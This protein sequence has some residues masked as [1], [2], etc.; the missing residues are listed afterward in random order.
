L[1]RV[2]ELDEGNITAWLWLSTVMETLEEKQ[3]CLENVLTLDPENKAART[4][5]IR[6]D[7]L[8]RAPPAKPHPPAPAVSAPR[9]KKAVPP[10][11]P[12]PE[13]TTPAKPAKIGGVLCP[14]CR[15]TI[16]VLVTTCPH[17]RLP[18]VVNCPACGAEVDVERPICA[19]CGQAMGYYRRKLPYFEALAAA[20]QEQQRYAEAL[21]AWQ[22]VEAIEPA[23]P[24]LLLHLGKAQVGLGR[25]DR[26][27]LSFQSALKANPNSVQTHYALGELLRQRGEVDQA[28]AHYLKITRLDPKHG[29]A[30]LRLGQLYEQ[31]RRRQEAVQAYRRAGELLGSNSVES[32]QAR[33]QLELLQPSL[34]AGMATGW[35]EFMRQMTGPVLIC[36]MAA[37]LDSGLR[38]WWIHWTGWLALMIAPLGAFLWISGDSLPRNPLIR[39]LLGEEGLSSTR[40]RLPISLFGL[41]CWFVAFGLL[42]LPID[43][44]F[45]LPPDS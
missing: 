25:L 17:C 36:L 20:Y 44:S 4:G 14:F 19:G 31:A 12:P 23:Y 24:D 34:P 42:I 16:S 9:P 6:L 43:Q 39:L 3:V 11:Q 15:Q 8:R 22:A 21:K 28:Y 7:Q 32:V 35:A 26:A 38:P 5:L 27:S 33:Q 45:P 40:L 37:L 1:V 30:W 13:P 29:L 41:L 18:L 2:T 10:P